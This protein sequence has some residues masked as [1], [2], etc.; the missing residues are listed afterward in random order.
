LPHDVVDAGKK[1]AG[2]WIDLHAMIILAP[3]RRGKR[4]VGNAIM[5]FI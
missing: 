4:R 5:I 2:L 1:C 3:K